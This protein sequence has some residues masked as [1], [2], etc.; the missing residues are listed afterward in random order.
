MADVNGDGASEGGGG[1]QGGED[2]LS[3]DDPHPAIGAALDEIEAAL[4]EVAA[5]IARMA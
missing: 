1:G 5:T 4:D 2:S 3:L